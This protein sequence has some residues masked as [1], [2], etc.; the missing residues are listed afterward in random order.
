MPMGRQLLKYPHGV[1]PGFHTSL[2]IRTS[3]WIQHAPA[4]VKGS[5]PLVVRVI[6]PVP[7]DIGEEKQPAGSQQLAAGSQQRDARIGKPRR[8]HV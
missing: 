6:Q 2:V 8:E 1:L 4:G 7:D 5:K 3:I